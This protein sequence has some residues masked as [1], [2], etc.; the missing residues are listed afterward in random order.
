MREMYFEEYNFDDF[1]IEN[2]FN[3]KMKPCDFILVD[4]SIVIDRGNKKD[5]ICYTNIYC[6]IFL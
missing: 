6:I 3:Y 2:K 1:D 4:A 5:L